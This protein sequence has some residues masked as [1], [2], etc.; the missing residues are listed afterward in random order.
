MQTT[1]SAHAQCNLS[2][3]TPNARR[4][5][6]G[7]APATARH[8]RSGRIPQ[9]TPS[10]DA[11]EKSRWM[12]KRQTVDSICELTDDRRPWS[13]PTDKDTQASTPVPSRNHPVGLAP[14]QAVE[15]PMEPR[16]VTRHRFHASRCPPCPPAQ[17]IGG[18]SAPEC[19]PGC[20]RCAS[21]GGTNRLEA[22][23]TIASQPGMTSLGQGPMPPARQPVCVMLASPD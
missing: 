16:V 4:R 3:Q 12:P 10:I 14:Y 17:P 13:S 9:A 22:D 2:R 5:H 20:P 1:D 19:P 11:R 23:P 15:F 18:R 6:G 7:T 21:R 8:D